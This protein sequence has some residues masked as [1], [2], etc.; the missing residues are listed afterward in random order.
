MDPKRLFDFLAASPS[1][2]HAVQALSDRLTQEGYTQLHEAD[3]WTLTAGGKYF[4]TRNGSSLLAFRVPAGAPAGF[5]MAAAHTD[6]PTFKIK[7]NPEKKAGP[8]V[9]LSTE[10]Y[11]GMLMGTWF[12]RPLSV[13]G[14]VVTAKDGKLE[15]KL[16]DVDRDLLVIPSVAI[17]MNRAANDGFKLMANVDTLPLYGMQEAAGSIRSVV[18]AAAGVQED[19]ILGEDL[20]LYVRTR[21]KVFGAKDEFVLAP[22]L[23][24][25]G[26]VFGLLEGFLAAEPSGSVPVF[27][28][29]DNEEVG[30]ETKQGA[31]SSLLSDTLRRIALA[32]GL[33]EEGYLRLLAQSFLVSADNAHAVHPNHPEYADMTN[34]PRMNGGV[35]I[36]HNANQK[37]TTDAVSDAI[38]SEICAK[39]G[40]P[41]QHFANRS[42]IPGGST[43]GNLSNAH[44]SMNTVDIGL[45]QLAMHASYETAGCADVDYMI[46]ALRQFYKTDIITSADGEYQLV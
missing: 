40:V 15:T 37:Y 26:C 18:A 36:K 45:A 13:A 14:R 22:Q 44:V 34:T 39:A 42:D 29:F 20:S 35:V 28:A 4:V 30:S 38:F 24:D 23:D 17:H 12:D 5:L 10:K 6:S 41:V 46:R 2:Y 19:E 43:L 32:L 7:H 9:Q 8:Y 21:G 1:C 25:L 27:C 16:V 31:A 3:A 33:G 11:G